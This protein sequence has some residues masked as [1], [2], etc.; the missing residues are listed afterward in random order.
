MNEVKRINK[1]FIVTLSIFIALVFISAFIVVYAFINIPDENTRFWIVI[2]PILVMFGLMP[3]F[4]NRFDKLTNTAY[5][6]KIRHYAGNPINLDR[7]SNVANLESVLTNKSFTKYTKHE[8]YTLYYRLTKDLIRKTFSKYILEVVVVVTNNEDTFYL[9][10]VDDDVNK[11]VDQN[12]KDKRRVEKLLI[13]Q[14]KVVNDLTD[15]VKEAIKEIV[16]V[17]TAK[18]IISTIN[19]GIHAPSKKAVMLY[20]DTYSPSLYYKEHIKFIKDIL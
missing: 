4:K 2:L 3:V 12:A 13:T 15:Q 19:I 11:L 7:I 5:I 16:F 8:T 10:L 1:K 20:S 18:G 14:V 17:R 6:Y 9:D